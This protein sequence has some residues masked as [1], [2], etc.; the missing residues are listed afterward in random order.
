MNM[1]ETLEDLAILLSEECGWP[2][3]FDDSWGA[4]FFELTQAQLGLPDDMELKL[5][6]YQ[7]QP[8]QGFEDKMQIYFLSIEGTG[9]LHVTRLR[10]IL[11]ELAR[12]GRRVRAG[13][14]GA[15][16]VGVE[17]IIFVC[18]LLEPKNVTRYFCHFQ[19]KEDGKQPKL[20]IGPKW[21]DAQ[22]EAEKEKA[23]ATLRNKLQWP[24]KD[25]D[26]DAWKEEWAKAF[27]V[28]HLYV[29]KT[30]KQL[31]TQLAMLAVEIKSSILELYKIENRKGPIHTLLKH[32]QEALI[33]DL[34]GEG[35]ADMVAQTITYGLFSARAT[36]SELTGIE[37]LSESIPPTNPFLR[38]LFSEFASL[39]GNKPTDLDFDDLSLDELVEMLNGVNIDAILDEFGSQFK[40]GKQDPLIHFY[41]E[42]LKRYDKGQKKDRGVWYTPRPIAD[43][44][45]KRVHE[46]LISE[47]NLPLGLAD[48]ST[49]IIKG[50]KWHRVIILDPALGP[51]TFL[52]S[53]IRIINKTMKAYWEGEGHNKSEIVE[54]WNEYVDESLIP[55]LVGIEIMMAPYTIAHMNINL[56]LKQ[57][58]Y[59]RNSEIRLNL[60][61]ANTLDPILSI[62]DFLP[63]YLSKEAEL[64]KDIKENFPISVIIGN[65]P[66]KGE[67]AND[68]PWI[69]ELLRKDLPDKSSSYFHIGGDSLSEANPK[70]LNDD[71]VKFIRFSQFILSKREWGILGFINNH[72]WLDQPTNRG[73]RESILQS[74]DVIDVIDL[75]GNVNA[76]EV[77]PTGKNENV[78]PIAACGV[79][80][81][82]FQKTTNVEQ[83]ITHADMWGTAN[84]KL[85]ELQNDNIEFQTI[86]PAHPGYLMHPFDRDLLDEYTKGIPINE[87][88]P[89]SSLAI[90]TARDKLTIGWNHEEIW[91]RINNFV[92]LKEE[93]A[94]REY[95][96][97]K[98]A[99]DWK[100]KFA[101]KDIRSTG[102]SKSY[103][104]SIHYRPWDFR[105]TYYTGKTKGFHCMPRRLV[106]SNM[107]NLD[108]IGLISRR[109]MTREP[110]FFFV[111]DRLTCDGVI[112]SDNKGGES[113]YP[114]FISVN[115][116][117]FKFIQDTNSLESWEPKNGIIPN[118]NHPFVQ[119]LSKRLK[120]K[121]KH[122]NGNGK[123]SC[124]I[125][126]PIK[127]DIF[128]P[129]D[130]FCYGYAVFY[131]NH[132]RTKYS[133]YIMKSYPRL[134]FT[135]DR[136]LFS[137]LVTAGGKLIQSHLLEFEHLKPLEIVGKN[138]MLVAGY[139]KHIEQEIHLNKDT[140]IKNISNELWGYKIGVHQVLEKWLKVRKGEVLSQ[141]DIQH[142]GKII[143][144][145]K[146]TLVHVGEIDDIIQ[147]KGGF[148]L[149]GHDQF[150]GYEG[151]I[152]GATS[153]FDF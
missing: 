28:E 137:E 108:N 79:N 24:D 148:P 33:K 45:V 43:F 13:E 128:T 61:L 149:E 20:M 133:D 72:G 36:G 32:F 89:L 98:D 67:S 35:F 147:N 44:I 109:Q 103:L 77:S 123:R 134:Q 11:K 22:P 4:P 153:L 90:M 101:Q 52:C 125:V 112:R 100:I 132:Y 60:V 14:S 124:W 111:S 27:T 64:S 76:K 96:L 51:G 144:A 150:S 38:E 16:H 140:K 57:T 56:Q 39:T 118:L 122:V 8:P 151:K 46:G 84:E 55:R 41:A 31:A 102:P 17:D 145:V 105:S 130:L 49:S 30:S 138:L 83:R 110:N 107:L 9:R 152:V 95:N 141:D 81:G 12:K 37:T 40:G 92:S 91:N 129:F 85:E 146:H 65:P 87:L 50:K 93:S 6:G 126:R 3:N 29:P 19:D 1:N 116:E 21:E 104:H 62:A 75:H 120:Y 117:T 127:K 15:I 70:S 47:H 26:L 88:F 142:Y 113:L 54:L 121:F 115:K 82:I 58:G 139:P 69:K 18:S 74:F 99:R 94:R 25:K 2:I 7:L 136:K 42:F 119:L 71:Y 86:T 68:I 48:S 10:A 131:S 5:A 34:D 73:M 66:Y 59:T 135:T 23:V 114:L 53:A 97:K 63:G 143:Q 80:I 106:M 78:F